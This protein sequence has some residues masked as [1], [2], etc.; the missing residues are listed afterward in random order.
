MKKIITI[1]PFLCIVCFC[2]GQPLN[3]SLYKLNNPEAL[4]FFTKGLTPTTPNVTIHQDGVVI[5]NKKHFIQ[6]KQI[7]LSEFPAM[8]QAKIDTTIHYHIQIVGEV[9][10]QFSQQ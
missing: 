5:N 9:K 6:L 2:Q 7:D 1:I 4:S 3:Q 10:D 8:P